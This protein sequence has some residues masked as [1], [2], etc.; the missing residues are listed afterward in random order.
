MGLDTGVCLEVL[1][2]HLSLMT[3]RLSGGSGGV[4]FKVGLDDCVII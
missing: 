1:S 2:T 3:V 4:V